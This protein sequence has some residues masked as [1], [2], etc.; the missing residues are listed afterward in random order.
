VVWIWI[1]GGLLLWLVVGLAVALVVGRGIRLADE[2]TAAAVSSRPLTTADIPGEAGIPT[3]V[4]APSRRRGIPLPPI[5]VGLAALAVTLMTIGYVTELAGVRG[6]PARLLSM[7]GPYSLPRMFVALVFAAAALVAVAG[8]GA[9]PGRRSWWLAVGLVGAGIATVKAGS[10]V[11]TETLA[12][13]ADAVGDTTALMLSAS[14]AALVLAVLWFLSRT[15]RRDRRRVLGVLALY[16]V[17]VVGL[18]AVSGAVP[19]S[20][21]ATATFLKES[22][23]ALAGVA[24]LM[25]VLVGVAPQLVLP[26]DWALRRTADAEQADAL[27]VPAPGRTAG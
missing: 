7:D 27:G 14:A 19:S 10:T 4:A 22:G 21:S 3:A 25:A 24:F 23:E 20:L 15:E 16:A 8:A 26:A 6:E 18:S 5:G 13:L 12:G 1:L 11:H 9:L 2:R 17:A